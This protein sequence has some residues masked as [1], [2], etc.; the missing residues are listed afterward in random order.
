VCSSSSPQAVSQQNLAQDYLFFMLVEDASAPSVKNNGFALIVVV[1]YS[2]HCFLVG[3]QSAK[4]T[5]R[6]KL[7]RP[8]Y[9]LLKAWFHGCH[10]FQ[11]FELI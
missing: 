3:Q 5:K 11:D 7:F 10:H 8:L 1:V 4:P 6:T 2:I 9:I